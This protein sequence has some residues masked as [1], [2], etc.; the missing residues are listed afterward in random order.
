MSSIPGL[1]ILIRFRAF[2]NG[3]FAWV[4]V[5]AFE[6]D[7]FD[8]DATET[9]EVD[10]DCIAA[11]AAADVDGFGVLVTIFFVFING[12]FRITAAA[13]T[14]AVAFSAAFLAGVDFGVGFAAAFGVDFGVALAD[15]GVDF[16]FISS[17]C[18]IS[19]STSTYETFFIDNRRDLFWAGVVF[20]TFGSTLISTICSALDMFLALDRRVVLGIGAA[21]EDDGSSFDSCFISI[22]GSIVAFFRT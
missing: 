19:G 10:G 6:V 21:F 5:D 14:L 20:T 7:A 1:P 18:W 22:F 16:F 8:V 11:I 12:V 2:L 15:F 13:F 3:F 17:S 4:G 9:H